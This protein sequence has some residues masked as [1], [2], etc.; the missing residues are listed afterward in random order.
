MRLSIKLKTMIGNKLPVDYRSML[1]SLFKSSF[2]ANDFE[3]KI[4]FDENKQENHDLRPFTFAVYLS[5]PKFDKEEIFLESESFTVNFS[6]PDFETGIM[7]YNGLLAGRNKLFEY[8]DKCK[9][10]IETIHLNKQEKT[11]F[12]NEA[13]FK[14]LSPIVVKE[15]DLQTNHD[16]FYSPADPEYFTLLNKNCA[17]KA[18]QFLNKSLS[19]D[20]IEVLDYKKI[21]VKLKG[22]FVEAYIGIFRL[23]GEP[24]LLNLLYQIGLGAKNGYGFGM[25]EVVK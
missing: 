8:K 15:S 6:T 5:N 22:H 3:R 10:K 23:K 20:G 19:L 16:K 17:M 24:E 11:I 7:L 14:M 13:V 25:M 21:P 18:E 1:L 12:K 2:A 4:Y 9:I